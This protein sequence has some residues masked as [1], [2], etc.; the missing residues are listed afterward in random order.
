MKSASDR[1][2]SLQAQCQKRDRL[3]PSIRRHTLG[4]L[5]FSLRGTWYTV[6]RQVRWSR[7]QLEWQWWSVVD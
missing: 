7:W 4:M 2:M 3:Y 1:T 6:V 5:G